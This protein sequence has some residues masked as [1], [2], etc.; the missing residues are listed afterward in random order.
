MDLMR[1]ERAVEVPVFTV[2]LFHL[3]FNYALDRHQSWIITDHLRVVGEGEF[4]FFVIGGHVCRLQV[5]PK[6]MQR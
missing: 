5:F 6:V 1:R 4:P 3:T 2:R